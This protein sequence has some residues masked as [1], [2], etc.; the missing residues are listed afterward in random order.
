[1]KKYVVFL[2]G[3]MMAVAAQAKVLVISDIDD[4]LKVSHILSKT[5]ATVSSLDEHSRFAGMSKLYRSLR[6][7]HNDIEFHYVSLAPKM[8]MG[9]QH[10]DFLKENK[11]PVTELH[12]NPGIKQ[13]PQLKQKVIR[14]LLAEKNP[15][16][17]INFGDNG[18]FDT[19][20]YNQMDKEFPKI[21][22]VTYIREAYSRLADS[23][24]PTLPGQV[25]F[26][27]SVEVAIDLISR[28]LLPVAAYAPIEDIVYK[29]LQKDDGNEHFGVM[30]FPG[31]QDCRDFRWTWDIKNP[32]LKLKAIRAAIAEKCGA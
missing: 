21:P 8:I 19:V 16:M 31:W 24:H 17:V 10:L 3:L 20:V 22:S 7:A 2:A 32:S 1:M 6:A 11:F 29:R 13:D 25:G 23:Q 9:K 28:H 26:V 5:R 4:T 27:T 30:V 15:E 12:M 18:Q 14:Q